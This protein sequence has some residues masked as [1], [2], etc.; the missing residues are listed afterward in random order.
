MTRSQ[1]S[2]AK[3]KTTKTKSQRHRFVE[4]AREIGADEDEAAFDKKLKRLTAVKPKPKKEESEQ[5][6]SIKK[7]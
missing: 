4:A 5:R 6:S 1:S 7:Q 2:R 3:P